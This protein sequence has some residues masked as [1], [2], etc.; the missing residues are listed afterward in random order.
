MR[1]NKFESVGVKPLGEGTEKKVFVNPE[2][3]GKIISEKKEL[4]EKDTHRQLKGRYYLTKIAHFLLPQN[5]PDISQVGESIEGKKT[6]D[7]ERISHTP[8]HALLQKSK[9]RKDDWE[10]ARKWII[11]EMGKGM[12]E[13]DLELERI[14]LGFN[15]DSSLGNY[16]KDEKG[17]VYYLE[18]F[19][20]WEIDSGRQKV[21]EVLFD[22]KQ[23]RKAIDSIPDQEKKEI[24][25]Q[26]LERLLVL[27]EEENQELR[28]NKEVNLADFA[29]NIKEIEATLSPFMSEEILAALYAT[30]TDEEAMASKEREAA[31]KA[32]IF[33]L[34]QLKIIKEKTNISNEEYDVLYGKYKNLSRAVGIINGSVVDHNR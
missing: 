24:C 28:K 23:L 27:L 32:L 12:G 3:E 31:K 10:I 18:S 2:N 20:P 30:T 6:A 7:A 15:V 22:E 5:I 17:N 13:L 11:A 1:L 8:G 4:V 34:P 33:I 26:Y 19:K 29:P 16:T 14:G 9:S 25:S 21:L